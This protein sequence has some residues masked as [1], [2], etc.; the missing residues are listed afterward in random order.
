MVSL[1][2]NIILIFVASL[3]FFACKKEV[4]L[5]ANKFV[6]KDSTSKEM[7]KL[8]KLLTDVENQDIKSY[9][10]SSSIHFKLSDIGFYYGIITEGLG[11][12]V[13]KGDNLLLE[14]QVL[15]L[16]GT[17]CYSYTGKKA[18][19]FVVG[20]G[21]RQRGL[22]EALTLLKDG[23]KAE[24]I[25]PSYLAYGMIGDRD[26]IPPR[27]TLIYKVISVKHK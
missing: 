14:Y 6:Q 17:L 25:V 15:T 18:K 3:L 24:F 27:A 5:P 4:Q 2:R 12:K 19:E 9:V 22:N 11:A 7:I 10:D 23:G 1:I 21:E 20:K 26:K 13:E 8:N 16:Q